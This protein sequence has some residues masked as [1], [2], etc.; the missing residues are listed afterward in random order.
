MSFHVLGFYRSIATG[1]ALVEMTPISD[2][3]IST[4][5]AT[6]RFFLSEDSM[7]FG[8]YAG[9]TNLERARIYTS[10][11]L[12]NEIRPS[13][14]AVLPTS[15][16]P[17]AQ[18]METPL[19]IPATQDII[20]DAVHSNGGT[21]DVIGV[22]FLTVKGLTPRPA[23]ETLTLRA[24][25]GGGFVAGA[26]SWTE[27]SGTGITWEYALPPG[28]YAIVG[29]EFIS[30]TAI[31]HRW[32][33]QGSNLRPGGLCQTSLSGIPSEYQ[34]NGVLGTWGTFTAPLMPRLEILCNAAD[35]AANMRAFLQLVPLD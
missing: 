22:A 26:K 23:G 4:N 24:D 20:F 3:V 13:N 14:S 8:A 29:S 30:T 10:W 35:L 32:I 27:A 5:P 19:R 18:W 6:T 1:T 16:P 21:Q 11:K 9:A 12:P 33:L 2:D 25:F 7:I 15:V 34:M 17:M 31:A 28:R